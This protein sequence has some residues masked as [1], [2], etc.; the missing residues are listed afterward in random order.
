M[1]VLV[2]ASDIVV[3]FPAKRVLDHVSLGVHEGDRIGIVGT[4]GDGK[5]TLLKVLAKQFSPESGEVLFKGSP[6]IGVLAQSDKLSNKDSVGNA[7][8]GDIPE[9][10][11]ASDKRIREIISELIGDVSWDAPIGQLSGGQRRRVDLA[12]LLIGDWD[13]LMLDEPTNHLDMKTISWLAQHLQQR[14]INGVGA[15][16]VITHDRWFLDEVALKMWEVHDGKVDPFE[17]GYSAYIQQR[18]ERNRLSNLAEEKRQNMIRKELAWLSRGARARATKPKFHVKAAQELIA[19]D[20]PLRNSTEL[21]QA[22][23]TRLGKQVFELE[24]VSKHYQDTAVLNDINWIIGPGDRFGILGENGSGKSTLLKIIS[25]ELAPDTGSIK[26]GKTVKIA[27]LSQQLSELEGCEND[28]VREVLGRYKSRITIDGKATTSSSLLERLGFKAEHFNSLIRDLSGGQKRRLQLLMTLLQEPNVLILDEPGNDMD[29]DMLAAMEDLLDSWPG[30]LLI[31]S[32]DRYLIERVTDSLFAL[33]D[34][35]IVQILGGV[36]DYYNRLD[37]QSKQ[38]ARAK[39]LVEP[40]NENISETSHGFLSGGD[41]YKARKELTSLERKIET[42]E[43]QELALQNN[44]AHIAP[45][46]YIQLGESEKERIA[47]RGKISELE[48][49]WMELSEQMPD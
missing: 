19:G 18:V 26:V 25:G 1:A 32:H 28:R 41:L 33:I 20:P 40:Q 27:M 7:V 49:R 22:A 5:S 21:K 3:E 6:L 4:N 34:S 31:V 8:V 24:H 46:D 14:W 39:A 11:W 29:T 9:H 44:M 15:L 23:M 37:E 48:D 2:S 47:L 43:A 38:A 45:S 10:V 13:I 42:L 17:G 35:N 30:T 12:K 36:D 16:L